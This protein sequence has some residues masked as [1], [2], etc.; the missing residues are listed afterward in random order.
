MILNN[1]ANITSGSS[2]KVNVLCE[3]CQKTRVCEYKTALKAF[4]KTNKNLCKVCYQIDNATKMKERVGEKNH[5][6]GRKH[7]EETKNKISQANSGETAPMFGKKLSEEAK[8]RIA[9]SKL[10]IPRSSETIKKMSLS[11]IGKY[12]GSQNGMYGRNH[13]QETK[14]NHSNFM[15]GKY[16]GEHNPNWK[17][18]ETRKTTL[19]HQIRTCYKFKKWRKKCLERDSF[20]CQNP[21]C[22]NEVKELQV[23]HIKPF[24]VILQENMID[25]SFIDQN[26]IEESTKLLWVKI[27][28]C[29][30]L[31]D[32]NNGRTLCVKCHKET[33]TYLN[34]TK[35]ILKDLKKNNDSLALTLTS[36]SDELSCYADDE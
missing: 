18:P 10:G 25:I 35:Q 1:C 5:F 24:A 32:I 21:L 26:N 12:T 14:D 9:K 19:F 7:S 2:K 15:K 29:E 6:Y 17:P 34:G 11:R 3:H 30:K 33:P 23:D 36:R 20:C 16:V 27:D 28:N 31:W 4:N 13:S 8:Q 22:D